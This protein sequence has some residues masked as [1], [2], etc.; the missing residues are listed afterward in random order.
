[1]CSLAGGSS[2]AEGESSLEERSAEPVTFE[3]IREGTG[4]AGQSLPLCGSDERATVFARSTVLGREREAFGS[5]G[6][7]G[8]RNRSSIFCDA[9]MALC[10]YDPARKG[11]N[12]IMESLILAQNERWRRVL[13]MQVDRQLW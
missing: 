11:R 6:V 7:S 4:R 8:G 2:G 12:H 5:R 1:M 13:S 9:R 3:R 10:V